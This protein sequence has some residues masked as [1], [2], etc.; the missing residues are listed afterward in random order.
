MG[1][2]YPIIRT[3]QLRQNPINSLRES[4]VIVPGRI[5]VLVVE[6]D[7]ELNAL[8]CELLQI[9]GMDTLSAFDGVEAVEAVGRT[10]VD[11]VLLDIMLPQ[12]DGLETCREIR[13]RYGRRM[14]I[15]VVTALDL[16][17]CRQRGMEAGADAYYVKPV[18]PDEIVEKIRELHTRPKAFTQN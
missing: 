12:R 2:C 18:D 10:R 3:L 17:E 14:P 11:A 16:E 5:R 9:H 1:L 6:D 7:E 15:L 4:H 13:R 8:A